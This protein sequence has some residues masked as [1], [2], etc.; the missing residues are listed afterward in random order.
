MKNFLIGVVVGAVLMY[1]GLWIQVGYNLERTWHKVCPT[2]Y[3]AE[4]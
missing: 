1:V 3:E 2:C 4:N